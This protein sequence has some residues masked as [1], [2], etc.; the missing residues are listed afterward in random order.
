MYFILAIILA[1]SFCIQSE[2]VRASNTNGSLT[3]S[4]FEFYEPLASLQADI[5]A[6]ERKYSIR[7]S[8]EYYDRMQ[9]LYEDWQS[10]LDAIDYYALSPEARVDYHLLRNYLKRRLYLLQK[11][12]GEF[13][14]VSHVTGF[15][16]E[17][18]E[19]IRNRRRG[20][21]P[22]PEMTARIFYQAAEDVKEEVSRLEAGEPFD[23]WMQAEKAADVIASLHEN[24]EEAYNFYYSYDPEFTWWAEKPFTE[25]LELLRDYE[26]MAGEHFIDDPSF[27][28]GSG[29][30]GR[31]AGREDLEKRLA[32]EY[33]PYTIEELIEIGN[34]Q[35]EWCRAEMLKAS[36]ELGFGDDWRAALEYVKDQHVPPGRQ[37]EA[38]NNLAEESIA[39]LEAHDLLTIPELAKETWRMLM[40]SPER[41][42]YAPFFLGGEAIHMSYP[43]HTMGHAEKVMSMRG[44]N[45]HFSM[46]T[47]HHELIPGHH[48]QFFINQRSKPYRRMFSTPFWLEGWALYWEFLLYDMGFPQTPEDRIGFLFWRS[49]RAARI[50]FT[51]NYQMGNMTP[52]ECIDF[53]V[54]E[55]GHERINAEAEVRGHVR[56]SNP[57]YQ[58]SYMI[59]G[60]QF[61]ALREEVLGQGI[62]EEKEFHDRILK[63]NNMPV[64]LLRTVLKGEELPR[65]FESSWKFPY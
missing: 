58:I 55:V 65:D 39:F 17:L 9:T 21:P 43:T 48:F 54:N 32:L 20:M 7:E 50:I 24:L 38:V 33:I 62:M 61:K 37:P 28:D 56:G 52:Q 10:F 6:L 15:A 36:N 57:L 30:T 63:E 3:G 42:R 25:L 44:N 12:K 16:E 59:G 18:Y 60:L 31:R 45:P 53:L 23:T 51:L 27:D 13:L 22:D 26:E 11:D 1:I 34:S 14:E 2:D 49:H 4:P 41:Q 64:E 47:V 40:M 35:F 8:E 29:I 46:A 5:G 19:F